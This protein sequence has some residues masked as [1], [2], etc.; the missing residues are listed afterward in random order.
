MKASSLARNILKGIGITGMVLVAAT[1]PYF[2]IRLLRA[3]KYAHSKN[4]W[5]EVQKTLY[6]LKDRG[7]VTLQ[8]FP[9]GTIKATLTK[10]GKTIT[11]KLALSDLKIQK[12]SSW[13]GV[14]RMVIFDVPNYQSKSRRGF[15]DHLKELGFKYAQKSVWIHPYP[16][17]REIMILRRY[18]N[19]EKWVIYLE[20]KMVEDD[21]LWQLKFK[22]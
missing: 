18:Y 5:R 14:W 9:D 17:H 12:Q 2:G 3:W 1:N 20:T 10:H 21:E 22:L 7:Y 8:Y 11:E 15:T 16:S 13:D 4:K 19:I 6:Y